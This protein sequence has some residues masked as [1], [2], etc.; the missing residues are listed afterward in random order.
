[1]SSMKKCVFV[2]FFCEFFKFIFDCTCALADQSRNA[3][4]LQLA[5]TQFNREISG[6]IG[7]AVRVIFIGSNPDGDFYFLFYV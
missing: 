5:E 2:Q 3:G 7:L 4:M 1:V 6:L